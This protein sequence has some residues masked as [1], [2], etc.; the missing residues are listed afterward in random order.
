M[1]QQRRTKKDR[2]YPRVPIKTYKW[3]DIRRSRRR[4][5]YPWTH[6]YKKPFD[7]Q[8]DPEPFTMSGLRKSKSSSTVEK[9]DGVQISD[10][11]E[12][13]G[14][15]G[16]MDSLQIVTEPDDISAR[17]SIGSIVIEECDMSVAE[18]QKPENI[19]LESADSSDNISQYLDKDERGPEKEAGLK[20]LS[21]PDKNT[22]NETEKE[23]NQNLTTE[24]QSKRKRKMSA[25]SSYSKMSLTKQAVL[26]KIKAAKNKIKVPKL[27][28]P[29]NKR[30][31]PTP[32][33]TKTVSSEPK[34]DTKKQTVKPKD[35]KPVYIHIPLKPP[36]GQTD[37]FSYLEFEDKP[38]TASPQIKGVGSFKF[39][40]KNIKRL[41]ETL[42][43]NDEEPS[44]KTIKTETENIEVSTNQDAADEK[45]NKLENN[46]K[47]TDN[48]EEDKLQEDK[49]VC[50]KIEDKLTISVTDS[51]VLDNDP[52]ISLSTEETLNKKGILKTSTEIIEGSSVQPPQP[53]KGILKE[54]QKRAKSEEPERKRKLSLES[55]YSRKSLSKLEIMKKLR[56][57]S[58]K[59]KKTFSI[60]RKKKHSDLDTVTP[61]K[62]NRSEKLPKQNKKKEKSEQPGKPVYIHIPLKPAEEEKEE[63]ENITQDENNPSS[64]S[65]E[66]PVRNDVQFIMLTA[67]SDDEVLDSSDTPETPSSD[68]KVFFENKIEELKKLAKDV[69][70]DVTD[71]K[72]SHKLD[73]VAEE[74][75]NGNNNADEI[76]SLPIEQKP[77]L[78]IEQTSID[79]K[80]IE[81]IQ[82]ESQVDEIAPKKCNQ[83]SERPSIMIDVEDGLSES[84]I[85]EDKQELPVQ[86]STSPKGDKPKD[87]T[88][89]LENTPVIKKKVSFKRRSKTPKDGSYEDIGPQ[90]LSKVSDEL[91]KQQEAE[92][93]SATD[94]TQSVSEEKQLILDKSI[95][96]SSKEDEDKWSKIS[97]HEYEPVN[98]PPGVQ[99]I[100]SSTPT[101][102]VQEMDNLHSDNRYPEIPTIRSDLPMDEER[103]QT[104][105]PVDEKEAGTDISIHIQQVDD[106]QNQDTHTADKKD[107]NKF[108][109]AWKQTTDQFKNKLRNM[110]KPHL[111]DESK[112]KPRKFK[113]EKPKFNLP[114]IPD[115]SKINLPSLPSFNLPRRSS[116]KRS[117]KER[118]Q[119]T[120]SNAGDSKKIS[121][122]FSTYPRMFKK[123]KK[124]KAKNEQKQEEFLDLASVPQQPRQETKT[125]SLSGS[126]ITRI[127]LN[128]E[129]SA[130]DEDME[131]LNEPETQSQEKSDDKIEY[132]DDDREASHIRY[133]DDIDIDDEFESQVINN[134]EYL[135]RWNRGNFN[136]D[137]D[138]DYSKQ[139]ENSRYEVTDLDFPEE[140]DLQSFDYNSN[141]HK[142]RYSSGSSFGGQRVGGVLEEINPDEFFLRQKGISQDNIEVGMYLSSEIKEAFRTPENALTKMEDRD[143]NI[144]NQSL[145]DTQNARKPIRKPKRKKTPHVSQERISFGE[146]DDE[147]VDVAPPS[148]PKRRSK[149]IQKPKHFDDVI[150]YQETIPVEINVPEEEN[151]N[152]FLNNYVRTEEPVVIID[153]NDRLD[154]QEFNM[155]NADDLSFEYIDENQTEKPAAPPRKQKSLKSLTSE[156]E[157]ILDEISS[158]IIHTPEIDTKTNRTDP[159]F[160]TSATYPLKRPSRKKSRSSLQSET[161]LQSKEFVQKEDNNQLFSSE[162]QIPCVEEPCVQ[163]IRD[164]MGYAVI[165]KQKIRYPPLPPPRSSSR[166]KRST[167]PTETNFF[168]VPR[169]TRYDDTPVR[170]LRNYSTLGQTK[171]ISEPVIYENKE[172]IDIIQYVE[173]ED[174]HNRDLQSG[175]VIKK[176]KDRP[177]PAPPRPP[178]KSRVLQNITSKEN[179]MSSET[180]IPD[181]AD[182]EDNEKFSDSVNDIEQEKHAQNNV[183]CTTEKRLITPDYFTHQETIT[184]GSLLVQSLDGGKILRDSELTSRSEE[185]IIPVS[186]ESDDETSSVPEDFK[187]LRDPPQEIN[188]QVPSNA[189]NEIEVLKAHKLQVID[190]DVDT[191]T[192]NK[193]LAGK[194]I[195]SEIDSHSI[196]TDEIHSKLDGIKSSEIRVDIPET[197]QESELN[198][199]ELF[200]GE[201]EHQNKERIE[202]Q[203]TDAFDGEKKTST[204][205]TEAQMLYEQKYIQPEDVSCSE[206]TDETLSVPVTTNEDQTVLFNQ[207]NNECLQNDPPEPP[208]RSLV[209]IESNLESSSDY[210]HRPPPQFEQIE[211]GVSSNVIQEPDV[212]DEPPPRPPQPHIDYIPSQPPASFYALRAQKYVDSA[213]S[214]IP[215]VPRRKRPPR[216]ISRSSSEDSLVT[217]ISRR[218]YNRSPEPSISQLSGQLIR[219]CSSTAHSA[220]KRLITDI[221]NNLKKNADGKLDLHVMTI[222]LLILIAGLILLGYGEE[223]TVVHLH[224]WEYFNPPTDL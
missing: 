215:K 66:T 219:T 68:N 216:S 189:N 46:N 134:D 43:T 146:S 129:E 192:V 78:V 159:D 92:D 103:R 157:S 17:N 23:E 176:M 187:K 105:D 98:P 6:L 152:R 14:G 77:D 33:V 209:N 62:E 7:E 138:A 128:F 162:N 145:P 56:E 213:E 169:Q 83:T 99:T 70:D 212:D 15:E 181:E 186:T 90:N 184:H 130:S 188:T 91:E 153:E 203:S 40:A 155:A 87:S 11:T 27:S 74:T 110:K 34:K 173:I 117:Q 163:D 55:S 9:A 67:P 182:E 21:E 18:N 208:P 115:K 183:P 3:E 4:G 69:V 166:K 19:A 170:P 198:K 178:R 222:I 85:K 82:I 122:D 113:F 47:S 10:V 64:N 127:P 13:G 93:V 118:Q 156:S 89:N 194:I 32:K 185:R 81:D 22:E 179:I 48:N 84:Y 165:D 54:K 80:T 150:P 141:H 196:Q 75:L 39:L 211:Y 5:G 220:L 205:L 172:N 101:L 71:S 126:D 25:E 199:T 51:E 206:K 42:P 12:N 143:F 197:L 201:T 140:S 102:N 133:R 30:K 59:I 180:S 29:V 131:K 135:D 114:K 214:N 148:R 1:D 20:N 109:L 168:T 8:L 95:T 107:P 171:K 217:P 147:D 174:E 44:A 88:L 116:T 100:F 38:H 28:F 154:H 108:Q 63:E 204:E 31:K 221:T 61:E 125:K 96:A 161:S 142:E 123:G 53:Q 16:K 73:P 60:N 58:E 50:T 210:T 35:I 111:P 72:I 120:E 158:Q 177:L 57:T 121:F 149:R 24:E 26:D 195:V 224:H 175:D 94:I 52:K 164:Y 2:K 36:P 132:L 207:E 86:Q 65:I 191:L 167:K 218:L 45:E 136:P 151:S 160:V 124:S 119:S 223:K 49:D 139:F 106:K 41:Q 202:D 193:L 79:N 200:Q 144:S 190:L 104:I 37:E 76:T 137:L 112:P 97:D